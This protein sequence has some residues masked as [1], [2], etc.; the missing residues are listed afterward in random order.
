MLMF[1]QDVCD[2]ARLL[3]SDLFFDR[4]GVIEVV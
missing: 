2:P 3:V 1:A 4:I